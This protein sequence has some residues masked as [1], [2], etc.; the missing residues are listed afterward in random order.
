MTAVPVDTSWGGRRTTQARAMLSLRTAWPTTCARCPRPL[1]RTDEWNLGHK[2]ARWDRPDLIWE[3]TN[4]QVE[5]RPC[6]DASGQGEA[7]AKARAEGARA[8]LDGDFPRSDD[9]AEPP[10]LPISLSSSLE[11]TW[12]VEPRL[13]WAHHVA[14]APDWLAPYLV[15]PED[16]SPPLAMTEVHPLAVC[17]YAAETCEHAWPGVPFVV[18]PGQAIAWVEL[19]RGITLRWWQR[20]A[21][22]RQLEHDAAGRLVWRT[23]VE[24]GTRRI[25]KSERLRSMALWRM[26]HGVDLFEP[27]QTIIHFGNKLDVVREVQ[28]KAWPWCEAQGWDVSRNN[29]NRSVTHPNGARWLAKTTAYSFDVHLG[30]ADECWD[31]EP[32]RITE[33]LE[34]AALE[35]ESAQVVLT[36]TS[37]RRATTLMKRRIAAAL[38]ADDGRTLLLLFG[39]EPG[40]DIFAESTWRAASAHWTQ[41]RRDTIAAKLLEA[42]ETDPSLDDPDPVGS[43]ANQYLNRWDLVVR[44]KVKGEQAID[45]EAWVALTAERSDGKPAAAAIES[46]GDGVSLVLAWRTEAGAVLVSGSNHSDVPAAAAALRLAGFRGKLTVGASL[47]EHP[48]LRTRTKR[49]GEGQVIGA[50]QEL[51]RLVSE[52]VVRHDG[53]EHLTGQVVQLRTAAGTNGLRM[54]STGRADAVKATVW[55]VREVRRRGTGLRGVVL[56]SS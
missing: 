17:S 29:N 21:F 10:P 39:M 18:P 2:L 16:A 24:S 46:Y 38:A 35:R 11:Q 34:P 25:G 23:V 33:D 14:T 32:V 44:P 26:E 36:S 19:S 12:T 42:R 50:V 15:V 5:C 3:P 8:A 43:W 27:G 28:E 30:L 6:S 49:S 7:L 47:V 45:A 53:G 52:G 1:A 51:Q 41:D 55:A 56:A 13:R 4:W 9:V 20:L 37:H 40:A 22:V 31:I 48:A 54:T